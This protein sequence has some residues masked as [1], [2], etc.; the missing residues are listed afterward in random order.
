[1]KQQTIQR[2]HAEAKALGACGKAA[3]ANSLEELAALFFSPQGREFCLRHGFPGR[4]LWTSIKMCCPDIARL[5]I[6]VDAGNIT[7]SL[8]GP[9]ALIGDTHATAT[10][11]DDACL[12]RVVA[13]HGASAIVTASGYAVVAAEAMPQAAVDVVLTDHALSL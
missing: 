9:T 3:R 6:Y 2:I 7:V 10:T 4:D 8:S 5:G 12:Y 13:M 11:S 1:M